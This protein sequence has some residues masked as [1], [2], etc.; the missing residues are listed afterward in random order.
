MKS[1]SVCRWEHSIASADVSKEQGAETTRLLSPAFLIIIFLHQRKETQVLSRHK[2]V[3]RISDLIL[4]RL[5]VSI[6]TYTT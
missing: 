3:K 5:A 6:T 4:L 1:L 2:E